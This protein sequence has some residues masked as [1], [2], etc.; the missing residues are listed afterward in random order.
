MWHSCLYHYNMRGL[1]MITLKNVKTP[2]G[3]VTDFS[4]DSTSSHTIDAK[5]QLLMLPAIIDTDA[6]IAAFPGRA[7]VDWSVQARK[8][9]QSGIT[10][11]F[12][13]EGL[14]P[15]SA[16]GQVKEINTLLDTAKN[17]LQ[18]NFFCDGN[19]PANF[20]DIG[21]SKALFKGI[22]TSMDLAAEIIEPPYSS[23]L[24]RLFQIA[25]QENLIVIITLLQ[26][27]RDPK[28][29]RKTAIAAVELSISLAQKYNAQLCLQHIRTREELELIGEAK[30]AGILIFTEIAYPHLFM[31]EDRVLSVANDSSVPFVPTPIDQEALWQALNDGSIDLIGSGGSRFSP[32]E[33]P[34][35]S[36]RLLLPCL[37]NAYHEKRLSLET[38]IA[39]TR[40]N[41]EQIF[42]LPPNQDVVLVDLSVTRPLAVPSSLEVAHS[43]A[44]EKV[45]LTGWPSHVITQGVLFSI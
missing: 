35:F 27:K 16:K 25:A 19:Q 5:N 18:I 14:S 2:S 45:T 12:Y 6:N 20:N 24:A 15:K 29:Q 42:R 33:D 39:V 38:L 41:A 17:P 34:S 23:A 26:G 1:R 28:E 4:L 32:V 11:V 10:A 30:K 37:L 13:G 22:K 43:S 21:K 31:K 40:V 8:I 44:W 7:N 9:L 36:G 3:A